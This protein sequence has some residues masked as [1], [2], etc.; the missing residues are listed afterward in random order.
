MTQNNI[1]EIKKKISL[2]EIN[3]EGNTL[4]LEPDEINISI[5]NNKLSA[6]LNFEDVNLPQQYDQHITKKCTDIINDIDEDLEVTIVLT[7]HGNSKDTNKN[8][9]KTSTNSNGTKKKVLNPVKIEG[10]KH[11]IA[12]AA[13][14]GGVG[15]ST[16]STNLAIALSK[17]GYKV[18]LVDTDIHGPSI[19][20]MMDINKEPDFKDNKIIPHNAFGVKSISISS[21][22]NDEEKALIWRGPMVSKA[23]NQMIAGTK[24]HDDDSFSDK[25]K[26]SIS[27]NNNNNELDYLIVDFPPGTSDIQISMVQQYKFSTAVMVTT[28]QDVSLLDVTKAID[29]F[30]KVNIDIFG[31]VKNMSYFTPEGST[32]KLYPFGEGNTENFCKDNNLELLAELPLDS[33]ISS[34]GDAGEPFVSKYWNDDTSRI[35]ENIADKIADKYN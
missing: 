21:L 11:L 10:V 6:I 14:K 34:Q 35:F 29:L 19:G 8:I 7:S 4:T 17:K 18:G 26:N 27:K 23:L 24:W 22:I 3:D 32:E 12:V 30:N 5:K 25:I 9:P 16:L 33:R 31:I 1:E 13:G 2:L 28:P 15:K 20:K